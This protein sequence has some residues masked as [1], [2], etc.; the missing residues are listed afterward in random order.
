MAALSDNSRRA[1]QQDCSTAYLLG[2]YPH[3]LF[4]LRGWNRLSVGDG[5]PDVRD[6]LRLAKQ[7]WAERHDG[8]DAGWIVGIQPFRILQAADVKTLPDFCYQLFCQ[9]SVSVASH[10]FSWR[11]QSTDSI[12]LLTEQ[13]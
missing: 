9:L 5:N 8:G 11:R 4:E 6:S 13:C 1:N 3:D 2:E 7:F 12:Q 10:D